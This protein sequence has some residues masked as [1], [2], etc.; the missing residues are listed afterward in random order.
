MPARNALICNMTSPGLFTAP[1]WD[2]LLSAATRK[3]DAVFLLSTDDLRSLSH[4]NAIQIKTADDVDLSPSLKRQSLTQTEIRK[5]G[6][7]I[8]S[9]LESLSNPDIFFCGDIT[10]I[11]LASRLA[12]WC[13]EN[14]NPSTWIA[15]PCCPF[16]SVPFAEFSAGFGSVL[17]ATTARGSSLLETCRKSARETPVGIL[18]ISDDHFGWLTAGTAALAS[19]DGLSHCILPGTHFSVDELCNTLSRSLQKQEH[20][21]LVMSTI[22]ATGYK[23]TPG[24][25]ANVIEATLE[26]GVR[27]VTCFPDSL[28]D[29]RCASKQD[30]KD[31]KAMGRAAI[32]LA[33]KARDSILVANH[34][35]PG[36][37][38]SLEFQ[39]AS[40]LESVYTLRT[41]PNAFYRAK[42]FRTTAALSQLLACFI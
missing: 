30:M 2:G 26:T 8:L 18:N 38:H 6:S 36:S 16:N 22:N 35:V 41:V 37:A 19:S 24:H 29:S 27:R 4:K 12:L 32:R 11:R 7:G 17:S 1:L 5:H 3:Y 13:R 9:V 21:L 10:A 33:R 20:V 23:G 15:L 25:L 14:A 40:L 28:P 31:S 39:A 42:T 34:C